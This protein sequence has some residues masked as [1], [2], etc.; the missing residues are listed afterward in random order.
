[1]VLIYSGKLCCLILTSFESRTYLIYRLMLMLPDKFLCDFMGARG[2][3]KKTRN[4]MGKSTLWDGRRNGSA[5]R[6]P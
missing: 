2:S 1:M 4:P 6:D 3:P 5:V